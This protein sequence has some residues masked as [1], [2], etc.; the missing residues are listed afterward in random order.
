M[1]CPMHGYAKMSSDLTINYLTPPTA[2]SVVSSY[3]GGNLLTV[4]GNGLNNNSRLLID[5]DAAELASYSST[6]LKYTIPPYSPLM[7]TNRYNLGKRTEAKGK[8][9]ADNSLKLHNINDNKLSTVYESTNTNCF[10]G[11]D[12][13][14]KYKKNLF[15]ILYHINKKAVEPSTLVGGKFEGSTDNITYTVI[16]QIQAN[17]TKGWN[18][19]RTSQPL[20][21]IYRY[22]R[23]SHNS[24]SSCRIS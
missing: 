4:V 16:A 11:W 15:K 18:Q 13:G 3:A 22:I 1:F 7:S 14:D 5:G 21:T 19:W 6:E 2:A 10:I 9:F 24:T 20:P 23:F 8:V 17:V 12:L